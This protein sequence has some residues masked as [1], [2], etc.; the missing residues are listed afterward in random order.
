MMEKETICTMPRRIVTSAGDDTPFTTLLVFET[1]SDIISNSNVG[2][3][4][5]DVAPLEEVAYNRLTFYSEKN[6][7]PLLTYIN[8]LQIQHQIF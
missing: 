7:N 6:R 3:Y 4:K 1:T 5:D 8:S 2:R